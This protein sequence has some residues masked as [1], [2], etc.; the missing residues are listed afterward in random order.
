VAL[1]PIAFPVIQPGKIVSISHRE[2]NYFLGVVRQKIDAVK[3]R[4]QSS[5]ADHSQT[6]PPEMCVIQRLI[7]Q[8]DRSP[9]EIQHLIGNITT[10]SAAKRTISITFKLSCLHSCFDDL[11]QSQIWL[12]GVV[13]SIATGGIHCHGNRRVAGIGSS[14]PLR[15]PGSWGIVRPSG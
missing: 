11:R 6:F 5:T 1:Q 4:V 3:I 8:S 15:G 10:V 14:L 2:K 12:H 13:T 7:L 9:P